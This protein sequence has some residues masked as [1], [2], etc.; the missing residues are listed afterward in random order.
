MNGTHQLMF[1]GGDI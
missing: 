1:Y